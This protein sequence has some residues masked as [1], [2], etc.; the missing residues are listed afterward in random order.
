MVFCV[1]ACTGQNGKVI[2]Q[3][4]GLDNTLSVLEMLRCE[5]CVFWSGAILNAFA[6]IVQGNDTVEANYRQLQVNK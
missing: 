3:E 4:I 1:L 5:R 6:I 2:S